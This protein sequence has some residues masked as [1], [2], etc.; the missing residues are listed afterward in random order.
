MIALALAI[1]AG[2][3]QPAAPNAATDAAGRRLTCALAGAGN[4][5]SRFI[6]TLGAG[7]RRGAALRAEPGSRWL[8]GAT[9][10]SI[11]QDNEIRIVSGGTNYRLL[12]LPV[13]A[14]DGVAFATLEE[15]SGGASALNRRVAKGI[16]RSDATSRADASPALPPAPAVPEGRFTVSSIAPEGRFPADCRI[17]GADLREISVPMDVAFARSGT[18]LTVSRAD[19]QSWPEAPFTITGAM[20]AGLTRPAADPSRQIV[21]VMISAGA[22]DEANAPVAIAFQII[23]EGQGMLAWAEVTPR[24]PGEFAGAGICPARP[25]AQQERAR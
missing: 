7:E 23:A 20:L 9:A 11:D 6:L 15:N 12:L 2:V 17:V 22:R 19:G 24:R 21:A 1:A 13:P 5:G 10:A 14:R 18:S 3:A 8:D 25:R 16:C 4:T